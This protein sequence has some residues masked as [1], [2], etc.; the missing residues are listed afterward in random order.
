[1]VCIKGECRWD[2]RIADWRMDLEDEEIPKE[3]ELASI[4]RRLLDSYCLITF[5]YLVATSYRTCLLLG[6]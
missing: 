5:C 2:A 3:A 6:S 4:Q 1:M